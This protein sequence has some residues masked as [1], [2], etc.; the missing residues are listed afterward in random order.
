MAK[1]KTREQLKEMFREGSRPSGEDFADFIESAVNCNDDGIGKPGLHE[2][3]RITARDK[4]RDILDLADVD[5]GLAWRLGL[6][7]RTG[8]P[9]LN[10]VDASGVSRVFVDRETGN[11]GIGTTSPQA[12][13]DVEGTVGGI[14]VVD[15]QRVAWSFTQQ[16]ESVKEIPLTVTFPGRVL[17]AEAMLGSWRMAYKRRER[18]KAIGVEIAALKIVDNCV[19][20][21][22]RCTLQNAARFFVDPY[23][24]SGDVIIMATMERAF[25]HK[26][27][28]AVSP[29]KTGDGK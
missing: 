25:H 6:A 10:L 29:D 15:F 18:I 9:G 23:Q 22:I 19:E 7:D 12:T 27:A 20:L 13:L 17:K 5:D 4:D 24:G 1:E 16:K 11:I 8:K 28:D 21:V 3:V 14:P 2:P 26:I